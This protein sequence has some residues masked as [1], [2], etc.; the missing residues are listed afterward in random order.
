MTNGAVSELRK[1]PLSLCHWEFIL[2]SHYFSNNTCD[3]TRQKAFYFFLLEFSFWEIRVEFLKLA[4]SEGKSTK[5][6]ATSTPG[7]RLGACYS[8][9]AYSLTPIFAF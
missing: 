3:R 4:A 7:T 9:A 6:G 8:I 1:N 5:V 2:C